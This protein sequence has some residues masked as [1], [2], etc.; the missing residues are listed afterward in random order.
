MFR[1]QKKEEGKRQSVIR[2][3]LCIN[4]AVGIAAPVGGG[5]LQPARRAAWASPLACG[6]IA[7][8]GLEHGT[9]YV[10]ISFTAIF[11]P[12][13]LNYRAVFLH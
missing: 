5:G 11:I 4:P 9:V 6:L 13:T 7:V 8:I 3:P 12:S 10:L 1:K 2:H